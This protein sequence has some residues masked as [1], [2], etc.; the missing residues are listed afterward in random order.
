LILRKELDPNEPKSE[1]RNGT[2][3]ENQ[4]KVA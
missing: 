2:E 1:N 3:V 4:K